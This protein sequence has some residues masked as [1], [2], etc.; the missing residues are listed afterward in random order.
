MANRSQLGLI[1]LAAA[2]GAV[3]GERRFP[4]C[5]LCARRLIADL[6]AASAAPRALL[7]N[8]ASGRIVLDD[9][10]VA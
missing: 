6:Y 3:Y 5:A 9:G 7:H 8:E 4:L 2:Q 10:V 1:N